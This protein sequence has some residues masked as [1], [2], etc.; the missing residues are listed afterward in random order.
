MLSGPA[1]FS[2]YRLAQD[3]CFLSKAPQQVLQPVEYR[4]CTKVCKY[5][6]FPKVSGMLLSFKRTR[7]FH[8]SSKLLIIADVDQHLRPSSASAAFQIDF[9]VV[10]FGGHFLR[11]HNMSVC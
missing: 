5:V 7:T 8:S 3:L 9:E 11:D 1:R 6:Q 4:T 10:R 2:D